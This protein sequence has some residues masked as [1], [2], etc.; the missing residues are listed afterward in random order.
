M[1]TLLPVI[2]VRP[3]TTSR[4]GCTVIG[5]SLYLVNRNVNTVVPRVVHVEIVLD[6]VD[7]VRVG[8][9]FGELWFVRLIIRNGRRRK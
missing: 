1:L 2:L 4:A 9:T 7:F 8:Q 3:V 5:I 6:V